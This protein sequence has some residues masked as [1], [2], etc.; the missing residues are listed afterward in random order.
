MTELQARA[1]HTNGTVKPMT[2]RV[3]DGVA[4]EGAGTDDW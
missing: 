4:R 2:I 1:L 3:Q